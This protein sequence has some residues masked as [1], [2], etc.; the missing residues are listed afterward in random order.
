MPWRTERDSVS[1]RD[2]LNGVLI[3]AGGLAVRASVPLRLLAANPENPLNWWNT[4]SAVASDACDGPIGDDPRALR[5]GNLPNAFRVAHW[6]RDRRLTFGPGSVTLATGCDS[7]SGTFGVIDDDGRYDVIVVGSGIA[8]LSTACYLSMARPAVRI[9]IL[10]ANADPGGNSRRDDRAPIPV[11]ASTAGSYGVEPYAEFQ[12]TL[13]GQIGFDWRKYKVEPPFYSYYFDDRAPGVTSGARGWNIDTFGTGVPQLPYPPEIV[14]QLLRC[15]SEL[16]EWQS[17]EGAPTD[18]ADASSPEYDYL[19]RMSFHDYLVNELHVDPI[20]SDFYTRYTVDALGGTT[21][22]VNAHSSICFLSTEYA[23]L[24]AFPGGN[25]GLARLMTKWLIKDAIAGDAVA[26][27][28]MRLSALDR[29]NRR[30]RIRQDAVAVRADQNAVVYYKGERFHRATAKAVVLACGSHTSKHLV[31]HLADDTRR[32][33]WAALNTVPVPVANVTVR[34]AAPFVDAGLGYNQY[35]WGSKFWADF[36]V[37]DW[38]TP[39]RA[40]RNRATVLTF[41]GG[42]T[43]DAHELSAERF[44]LL[45]TP[46]AEYEQSIREDLARVMAGTAFDVDRD[47][48]AIYLYRWGHGMIMPTP[49][50]VFGPGPDRSMSP[51]WIAKQPLGRVS[52]AGQETEGTPSIDCAM[53]SGERAASEVLQHL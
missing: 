5:G 47:I 6:M 9:L 42:N 26:S 50:Q 48:T 1:R 18:P 34:S 20:V 31:D 35:W 19:S 15:R 23:E 8:G 52:F 27:R 37:A 53:A 41:F 36:V 10:D 17:R 30:V 24:F 29:P 25:A 11:I 22:Q 16:T 38:A 39:R 32:K 33:A 14:R 51:R 12:K 4:A 7:A 49:G 46:F 3:A 13:F 45:S 28:T 43:A 2:F 40:N 21:K 44:K